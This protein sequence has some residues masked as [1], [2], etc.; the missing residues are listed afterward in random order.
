MERK[1]L[2]TCARGFSPENHQAVVSYFIP[3]QG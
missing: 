1:N 2:L 3:C